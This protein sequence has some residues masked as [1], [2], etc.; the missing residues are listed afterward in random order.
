MVRNETNRDVPADLATRPTRATPP[1]S[2]EPLAE[3]RCLRSSLLTI[4]YKSTFYGKGARNGRSTQLWQHE[5]ERRYRSDYSRCYDSR[6]ARLSSALR[7]VPQGL[8]PHPDRPS[9]TWSQ[10]GA[11]T[12]GDSPQLC[13]KT[14][15]CPKTAP[16]CASHYDS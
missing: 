2:F 10:R 7:R 11:C 12:V 8:E 16:N 15:V 13:M 14:G 3:I 5:H 6:V 1:P 9:L 4:L